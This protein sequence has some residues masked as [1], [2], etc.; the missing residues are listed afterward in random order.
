M[1]TK[2][3]NDA[4]R[5]LSDCDIDPS[6]C[7]ANHIDHCICGEGTYKVVT[8]V[9]GGFECR[10]CP[11]TEL[12]FEVKTSA[13]CYGGSTAPYSKQKFW[14]SE[15]EPLTFIKCNHGS[16]IAGEPEC[17]GNA[18]TGKRP[19]FPRCLNGLHQTTV[20]SRCKEG[21]YG[22]ACASCD[23]GRFK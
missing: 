14:A 11:T 2:C 6:F 7:V 22:T 12:A 20:L 5:V 13:L 4:A 8:D 17:Y 18:T 23:S 19:G 15:D 9:Q 1:C 3:P 16:C 21:S 10:E